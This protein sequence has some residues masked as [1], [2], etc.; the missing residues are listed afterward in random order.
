MSD[1][2]PTGVPVMIDGVER[3]FL[4]T[5]NVIDKIQSHYDAG[6]IEA[7]GKLFDE[8]EQFQA[9]RVFAQAL[10]DDEV[11]REKWKNPDADI[12]AYSDKEIGWL[13]S[14]DNSS[15]IKTGIL[16]AYHIS[17]P[18]PDENDPNQMSGQQSN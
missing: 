2:R 17:I 9:L 15:E 10:L 18:D 13:I 6:M 12:K 4:F 3:H 11:E 8:R 14:A 1:L 16:T 7:L 5:L